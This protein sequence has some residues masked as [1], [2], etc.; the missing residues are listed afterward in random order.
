MWTKKIAGT[1]LVLN[2]VYH[3]FFFSRLDLILDSLE[4]IMHLLMV[5]RKLKTI[6]Q[7]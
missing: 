4:M 3:T 2:L 1:S 7:Y 5:E 6:L